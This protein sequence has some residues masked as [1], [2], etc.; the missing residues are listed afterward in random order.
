MLAHDSL[1]LLLWP[2][3]AIVEWVV[4]A[5]AEQGDASHFGS[6]DRNPPI[7]MTCWSPVG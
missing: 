5:P 1:T 6:K 2:P 3:T 4:A 7:Q